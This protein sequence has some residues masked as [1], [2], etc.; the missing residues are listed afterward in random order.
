MNVELDRL[1]NQHNMQPIVLTVLESSIIVMSK[2]QM[3]NRVMLDTGMDFNKIDN[4]LISPPQFLERPGF[5]HVN[6]VLYASQVNQNV[7][8]IFGYIYKNKVKAVNGKNSLKHWIFVNRDM[9]EVP[10]QVGSFKT[11]T[12]KE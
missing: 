12:S 5:W 2:K 6:V 4:I 10:H 7:P 9:E 8:L 3:S 11:V 1:E